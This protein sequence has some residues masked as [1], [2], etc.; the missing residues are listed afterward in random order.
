MVT[1]VSVVVGNFLR[2]VVA[3]V[4]HLEELQKTQAKNFI[5]MKF[6]MVDCTRILAKV[7][8][9]ALELGFQSI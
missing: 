4:S 7:V 3:K 1:K 6:N 9:G 5:G 8:M 2:R